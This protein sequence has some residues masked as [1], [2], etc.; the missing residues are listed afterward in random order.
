MILLNF[1]IEEFDV[2]IE[3]GK[4]VP[5]EEQMNVSKSGTIIILDILKEYNIKATFFCT[6]D[7]A[8]N[9]LEIMERIINEGHEVSSHGYSHSI[10]KDSDLAESKKIL[11]TIIGKEIFGFRMPKMQYIDTEKVLAAGY[12]YNS[13]INPM[14]LP[15]RY[16][17]IL[18]N[19]TI[20]K[21]NGLIQI[22]SSVV[23]YLRIPL[24]WL[25]FHN[26]SLRLY[27]WITIL[28]YKKDKYINVYFHP[29][30]FVE[31]SDPKYGLPK[32][33]TKNVGVNMINRFRIYLEKM[34]ESKY[35]FN[36]FSSFLAPITADNED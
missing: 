5:F 13:S 8:L 12:K 15:G 34:L 25:T 10:F 27:C 21:E 32:Y 17:Y 7:F 1:D 16:N 35:T 3:Y 33:I 24:F 28:T 14:Y 19:R 23:P 31:I 2:P 26:I 4:Y 20:F 36:T 29:W 18:K 11:E 30:E 22:P 6:V 9:A